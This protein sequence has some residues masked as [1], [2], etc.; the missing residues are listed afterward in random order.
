MTK[1]GTS[2]DIIINQIN[3]SGTIYHLSGSEI[4]WLQ[5][6]GVHDCVVKAM[7]AT[8]NLPPPVVYVNEPPPPPVVYVRE[9]PP[10]IGVGFVIHSR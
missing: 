2:D 9:P 6:S 7:Q 4:V 1:S 3:T 10:P 8:A 5:Q